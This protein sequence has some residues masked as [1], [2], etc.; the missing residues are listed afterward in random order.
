M[1]A[2]VP[3]CE[4][5]PHDD[6]DSSKCLHGCRNPSHNPSLSSPSSK[7]S[8]KT[9]NVHEE[10][11]REWNRWRRPCLVAN[12]SSTTALI[13]PVACTVAAI[14][15]TILLPT[16]PLHGTL[17]KLRAFIRRMYDS[18]TDDGGRAWLRT[19]PARRLWFF[20]VPAR[21]PQ[22]V[23]QP[24]SLLSLFKLPWQ[25]RLSQ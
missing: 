13:F 22:S 25:N 24:F 10:H 19:S 8:G 15:P 5:L 14:C 21:L 2:A 3:G 16:P 18:G 20:Q 11:T 6:S 12:K 1:T 9:N 23:P 7:Y 17:A 4:Q